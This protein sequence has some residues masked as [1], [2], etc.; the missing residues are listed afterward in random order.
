MECFIADNFVDDNWTRKL[1]EFVGK[2]ISESEWDS[3]DDRLV[4]WMDDAETL[5]EFLTTE[6]KHKITESLCIP[7]RLSS[8]SQTGVLAASIAL[9]SEVSL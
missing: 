3:D 8:R 7:F 5:S 1:H 6:L 2:H 4:L 9:A